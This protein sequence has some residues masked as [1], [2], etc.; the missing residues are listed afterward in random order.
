[1]SRIAQHLRYCH[2]PP[3]HF[4]FAWLT[5]QLKQGKLL[6]AEYD[7][8]FKNQ[9]FV[10]AKNRRGSHLYGGEGDKFAVRVNPEEWHNG[11]TEVTRPRTNQPPKYGQERGGAVPVRKKGSTTLRFVVNKILGDRYRV[12]HNAL[13]LGPEHVPWEVL[14]KAMDMFGLPRFLVTNIIKSASDWKK[15]PGTGRD[16]AA[17]DG[18][19]RVISLV[20]ASVFKFC[21]EFCWWCGKRFIRKDDWKP[22][23]PYYIIDG[24]DIDHILPSEK[25]GNPSKLLKKFLTPAIWDELRG[26]RCLCSNCHA[27]RRRGT[28]GWF[29]GGEVY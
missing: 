12:M 16:K 17:K 24:V 9:A 1:M 27:Q 6:R 10:S 13:R 21:Q 7:L 18:V 20:T 15:T 22:E 3:P 25:T 14:L 2:P 26:C 11:Y 4:F 8:M 28:G 23:N 5:W 29:Y 19:I